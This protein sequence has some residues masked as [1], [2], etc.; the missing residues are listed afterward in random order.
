LDIYHLASLL[1]FSMILIDFF[2]EECCKGTE[3]IEGWY[4]HEDDGEEVGGPFAS[5]EDAC[6]AANEG[7]GWSNGKQ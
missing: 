7:M 5:Q 6:V 3:L 1:A 4:W 2:T